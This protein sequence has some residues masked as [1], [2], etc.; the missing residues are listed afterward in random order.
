MCGRVNVSD[1]EGVR[2]LLAMMGMN[3]NWQTDAPR[4]NIAPTQTLNVIKLDNAASASQYISDLPSQFSLEAMNWGVS[5]NVKGKQGQNVVK[6]VSNARDDK[7]WSSYLWRSM[8]PTQRVLIPVNGFYEWRRENKKIAQ[9]YYI[10]P[11]QSKAM[12]LAGIYRAAPEPS[13]KHEVSFITTS[14]S[15]AMSAVHDRMP[16]V[17]TMQN[18][19]MAWIQEN[20]KDSLK[21]LMKPASNKSLR[22]TPVSNFVNKSSNEGIECI[23]EVQ[24]L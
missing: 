2:A 24:A 8:I 12:F 17:L 23:Q 14:A 10:H 5:M 6:R 22:F 9:A 19:A 13:S 3:V 16:V 4:Y 1:H 15:E 21:Q 20:D 18:E 7:V 11:S